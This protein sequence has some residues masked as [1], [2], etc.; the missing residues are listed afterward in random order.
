MSVFKKTKQ[1][2][3]IERHGERDVGGGVKED[4]E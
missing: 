3:N 1:Q 2:T 4:K